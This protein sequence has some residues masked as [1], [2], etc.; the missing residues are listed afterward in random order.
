MRNRHHDVCIPRDVMVPP[1]TPGP[2]KTL[3][4]SGIAKVA[5]T[6]KDLSIENGSEFCNVIREKSPCP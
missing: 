6:Y 1:P 3:K 5:H 4:P 2:H